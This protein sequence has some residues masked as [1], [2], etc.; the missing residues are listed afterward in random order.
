MMLSWAMS[1]CAS[2]TL[3]VA[4]CPRGSSRA[5]R[6][7]RVPRTTL[8]P[9]PRR[10]GGGARKRCGL[11]GRVHAMAARPPL[12]AHAVWQRGREAVCCMHAAEA[13]WRCTQGG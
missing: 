13:G 10:S 3:V 7:R 6:A 8:L 11:A 2:S 5:R 9:L 12:A 4:S 1:W